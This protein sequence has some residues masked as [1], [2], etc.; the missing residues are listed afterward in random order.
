MLKYDGFALYF[1]QAPV[2]LKVMT[3]RD[4]C[5]SLVSGLC[6][7]MCECLESVLVDQQKNSY[8]LKKN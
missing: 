4:V 5:T 7:K 6:K 1:V 8:N 3:R 2:N